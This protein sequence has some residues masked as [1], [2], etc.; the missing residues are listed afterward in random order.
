[1]VFQA[2]MQF[3]LI[4]LRIRMSFFTR[5]SY[6]LAFPLVEGLKHDHEGGPEQKQNDQ[7][8]TKPEDHP[9]QLTLDSLSS[10]KKT[11]S[12][13]L[14]LPSIPGMVL[15]VSNGPWS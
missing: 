9:R 1:M 3:F 8:W 15:A 5:V 2:A 11:Y 7:S 14:S 4:N 13:H 6:L 12:R 10:A